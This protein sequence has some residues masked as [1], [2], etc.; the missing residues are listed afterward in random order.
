MHFFFSQY[1]ILIQT[2][3]REINITFMKRKRLI[4]NMYRGNQ[5]GT[6]HKIHVSGMVKDTKLK[7][8]YKSKS[9]SEVI[10]NVM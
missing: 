9:R 8:K 7:T 1:I 5:G 3:A 4:L 6:A 2:Q 10:D